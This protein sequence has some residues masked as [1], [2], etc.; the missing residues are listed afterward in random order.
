MLEYHLGFVAFSA[1]GLYWPLAYGFHLLDMSL[2]TDQVLNVLRSVTQ[3]GKSILLTAL[4]TIII[5]YIYSIIGFWFL[6]SM[7]PPDAGV[8]CNALYECLLSTFDN[9]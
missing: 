6:R 1:L 9:G 7:Y 2:R 3:N 4:L 5:V 8:D